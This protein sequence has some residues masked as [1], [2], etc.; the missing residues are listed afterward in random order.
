MEDKDQSR[1]ELAR[2]K[3]NS[4]VFSLIDDAGLDRFAAASKAVTFA[5][6]RN[7][8]QEGDVGSTFFFIIRG[9]VRVMVEG[10]EEPKVL[11][12][13]G[14]GQFF[15]EMAVLN[16]EPRTASVMAI[17]ETRCLEFQKREVLEILQDYPNVR[18]V[19]GLVG[20]QRAEQLLDAQMK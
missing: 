14:A 12:R 15:G 2:F 17:G 6:G 7:I 16:D 19:L 4:K 9:G 18:Q 11:A 10:F 1:A 3:S 13:L 5:A 8:I 20:L